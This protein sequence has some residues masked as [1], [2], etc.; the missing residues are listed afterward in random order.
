VQIS[1]N[2]TANSGTVSAGITVPATT[3]FVV[4]HVSAAHNT[5]NYFS[6]GSMTFTKGGAQVAM[7]S[8]G[9]FGDSAGSS[10]WNAAMFYLAAPDIGA[11]KTL[12][13]DWAGS[14]TGSESVHNIVISFWKGVDQAS[15]VRDS[16][17]AN[18][19]SIPITSGTLTAL[20]GDKI[21][22]HLAGYVGAA[23]GSGTVTT[24]SNL[25]SLT[26][27]THFA[28]AELSLATSDP[29][30]DTTVGVTA[31]SGYAAQTGLIAIVMKPAPL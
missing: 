5:A 21:L 26:E 31:V 17:G 6:G 23:N 22:A 8:A 4:V 25:T 15:P 27:P 3:D 19:T 20:L 18:T 1:L 30:G 14:A 9:G 29:S 28:Y 10:A 7:T 12:N 24:W 2:S 16:D 13:F 11:S